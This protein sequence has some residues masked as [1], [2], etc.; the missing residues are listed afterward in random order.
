MPTKKYT[1]ENA[2]NDPVRTKITVL[3]NKLDLSMN[4]IHH[5]TGFSPEPYLYPKTELHNSPLPIKVFFK[6][7]EFL[8]K[9]INKQHSDNKRELIT[10][11]NEVK[12]ILHK[13][14]GIEK[15]KDMDLE[16]VANSITKIIGKHKLGSI[17]SNKLS[18]RIIDSMPKENSQNIYKFVRFCNLIAEHLNEIDPELIF[19]SIRLKEL[20]CEKLPEDK[21][22]LFQ[23]KLLIN[24]ATTGKSYRE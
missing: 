2:E 3:I 9:E 4:R 18:E 22:R 16:N 20:Y 23:E 1:F 11:L 5:G 7:H 8:A 21:A 15:S 19:Y 12:A 10:K 24:P 13:Q 14:H 6:I 17:P